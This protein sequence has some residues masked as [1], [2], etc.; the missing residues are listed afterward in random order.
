M[1]GIFF[2]KLLQNGLSAAFVLLQKIHLELEELRREV[3]IVAMG[4]VKA[5]FLRPNIMVK[6][7]FYIVTNLP[8]GRRGIDQFALLEDGN[9]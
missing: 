1:C 2:S 6:L 7:I 8:E 5:L 4:I 9:L 3:E